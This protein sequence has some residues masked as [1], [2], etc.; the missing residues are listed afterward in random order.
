M[1]NLQKALDELN[2]NP[3]LR[4]KFESICIDGMRYARKIAQDEEREACAKI[5]D[6]FIIGEAPRTTCLD[7]RYDLARI[8]M[9]K[10]IRARK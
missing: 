2:V 3:E 10:R 8:D 1:N 5:C 7:D 4:D 6:V 9:A